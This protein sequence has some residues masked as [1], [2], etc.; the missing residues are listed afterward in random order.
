M[1]KGW[2]LF[3]GGPPKWLGD[4]STCHKGKSERIGFINF[5]EGKASGDLLLSPAMLMR[6][7]REETDFFSSIK[8]NDNKQ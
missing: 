6:G 3:R 1:L 2:N 7:C 5:Q 4:W 8:W